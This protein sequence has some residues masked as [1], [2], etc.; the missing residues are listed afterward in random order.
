M[1]SAASIFYFLI[2]V[3]LVFREPFCT[4]SIHSRS[5]SRHGLGGQ[6]TAGGWL[7]AQSLPLTSVEAL[8]FL[9][10]AECGAGEEE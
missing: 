7:G 9:S 1:S 5:K 8:L 10:S 2:R 4:D 3:P 6:S